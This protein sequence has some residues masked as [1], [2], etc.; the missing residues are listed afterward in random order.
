MC[1]YNYCNT[2][3]FVSRTPRDFLLIPSRCFMF[4]LFFRFFSFSGTFSINGRLTRALG[5][6]LRY[7]ALLLVYDEDEDDWVQIMGKG[8]TWVF[9]L[10][11]RLL[12]GY[13]IL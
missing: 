1:D 6:P 9:L 11:Y 7:L 10:L 2:V 5:S 4:W 12:L 8:V 3:F 13:E